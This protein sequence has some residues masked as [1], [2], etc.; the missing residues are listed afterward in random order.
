MTC[1][2]S[3]LG[4]VELAQSDSHDAQDLSKLEAMDPETAAMLHTCA[5]QLDQCQRDLDEV[6]SIVAA[7]EQN[8]DAP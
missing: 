8:R 1:H 7:L 4:N 2:M 3:D 5:S 6:K